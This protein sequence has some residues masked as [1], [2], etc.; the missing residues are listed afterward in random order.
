M[1][2]WIKKQCAYNN[3]YKTWNVMLLNSEVHPYN[4][5]SYSEFRISI[6]PK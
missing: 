6:F 5:R 4:T 2:I 1:S 3:V